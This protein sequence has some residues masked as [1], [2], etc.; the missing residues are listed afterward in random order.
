MPLLMALIV[1][2][3]VIT[4]AQDYKPVKSDV[5]GRRYKAG[6]T[7]RYRLTTEEIQNGNGA[8]ITTVVCELKVVYD[9]TGIPYEEIHW[10]SKKKVTTKDTTDETK[11]ALTVK[12]YRISLDPA[13]RIDLPKIE[14][15]AMTG[16]VEDFNTF[17]VAIS[18]LIGATQ[19]KS[20]GDTFEVKKPIKA[21]FSNGTTILNGE[22]CFTVFMKM[23][24]NTKSTVMLH[25]AFMPTAQP[26]LTYLLD[27]MNKPVINDTANNFQMV[28]PLGNDKY[29]VQYGREMFYINS[30]VRKRDGKITFAEMNN[31]LTLHLKVFC[32]KNYSNCQAD[33]P[34]TEQRNLKLE[35]L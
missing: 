26:C 9:S 8:S 11:D 28:M 4:P 30:T 22:D 25:T 1:I 7:S 24:G 14:V 5:F 19:L 29:N 33:V 17:F 18:P 13:G 32:D 20:A 10:L 3:P 21:D 16:A 6:E 31:T 27:E 35:L 12:P 2:T 34:F 23:T 15:P